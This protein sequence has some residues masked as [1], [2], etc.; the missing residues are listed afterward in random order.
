M[1]MENL[2]CFIRFTLKKLFEFYVGPKTE[3]IKLEDT[4]FNVS[5]KDEIEAR[6]LLTPSFIERFKNLQMVYNSRDIKC[7]FFKDQIMF[8]I[9]TQKDFFELGS[10]FVPMSDTRQIE[11]FYNEI[12]AIYDMIDY[13]KLNEKTGL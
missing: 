13:F 6:Y 1:E 4:Q 2:I 5:S 9:N 8:A 12:I 10:L 7:A 11:K 3:K